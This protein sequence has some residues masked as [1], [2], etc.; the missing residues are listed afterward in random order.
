MYH[1]VIGDVVFSVQSRTP[2]SRLTRTDFGSY[3]ETAL[4]DNADSES[5][6][7]PLSKISITATWTRSTATES[8]NKVR[9]LLT[10]PQQISDGDGWNLGRWT[11]SQIE[12]VKS[13]IIHNGKAMKTELS[14]QL[15]EK[16]GASTS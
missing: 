5:T 14:I 11:I 9:E 4:I 15:L 7:S 10:V 16:R 13:E 3:S 2:I 8:V 6:G 1:L 12:E